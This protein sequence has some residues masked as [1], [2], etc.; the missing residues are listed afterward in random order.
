MIKRANHYLRRG[1]QRL[2]D[3]GAL[4]LTKAVIRRIS[5]QRIVLN[6]ELSLP[7][8]VEPEQRIHFPSGPNVDALLIA[9]C[10]GAAPHVQRWIAHT[11]SRYEERPFKLHAILMRPLLQ[12]QLPWSEMNVTWQHCPTPESAAEAYNASAQSS[13]LATLVFTSDRIAIQPQA[14]AILRETL[15]KSP[16]TA[17]VTARVLRADGCQRERSVLLA[18]DGYTEIKGVGSDPQQPDDAFLRP[19]DFAPGDL[20]AVRREQFLRLGGF[21]GGWVNPELMIADLTLRLHAHRLLTCYQP[22][23]YGLDLA[24][25][26]QPRSPLE[27]ASRPEVDRVLFRHRWNGADLW[28]THGYLSSAT[29]SGDE[30]RRALVVDYDFP[31][32]DRDSGSL[33]LTRLLRL[34]QILGFEIT[35]ATIGLQPR[36]RY[37][38][39]LQR[40]G[41][42]C[43]YRPYVRSVAD[44]LREHGGSYQVVML[45]RMETAETLISHV[46]QHCPEA[47][48]IFDT[49]DLHFLR[50]ERQA[51]LARSRRARAVAEQ[52]KRTELGLIGRADYTFVVSEVERE[53]LT[54][55]APESEVHVVSNI[56]RI[57]ADRA[58]FAQRAGILFVGGFSH[59]PNLDAVVYFAEEVLPLLRKAGPDI[60]CFVVGADP[61]ARVRKLNNGQLSILGYQPNLEPLLNRCRLSIAPLRFGAGVKGK[62]HQ[63]LAHGLPVIATSIAAEGMHLRDGES[64]LIADKPEIFAMAILRVYSD[65]VL[66]GRLSTNGIKVIRE[67]FSAAAAM[68]TLRTVL[69]AQ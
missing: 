50:L 19:V 14:L 38:P 4:A 26:A 62:I 46:R 23:A 30:R 1:Y 21:R 54:Q 8:T 56:H 2:R 15:W 28:G 61:P 49:V 13:A 22:Q 24:D 37:V 31:A 32:P 6:T 40:N 52:A 69:Q 10:S 63:S 5:P 58:T 43:L 34:M 9:S 3:R 42:R 12:E 68:K 55:L 65:E 29:S 67:H 57:A 60:H 59:P 53:L 7:A 17:A 51:E 45:C 39:D 27:A 16:R 48:L 66:W 20:V 36:P 35:L 11:R 18:Q 25:M 47:T 41:I 64:V 33:R 44:H